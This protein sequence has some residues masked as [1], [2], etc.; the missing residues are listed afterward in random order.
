MASRAESLE[1]AFSPSAP[2]SSRELFLGRFDQLEKTCEAITQRG[3]H[4]VIYGERGV[5]KTSLANIISTHI[6][7]VFVIK[8]TCHRNDDFKGLWR[9]ALSKVSFDVERQGVGFA[10]RPSVE[11]QQLDMF[12]ADRQDIDALDVQRVFEKVDSHLV[13]LFDEFDS[14]QNAAVRERFADTVKNLSDNATHVTLGFIGIGEDVPQLIGKHP[15]IERCMRQIHMPRMSKAE[16]TQIIDKG[17]SILDLAMDPAVKARIVDFSSGFPHFTH[18][19]GKYAVRECISRGDALVSETHYRRALE[20]AIEDVDQSIRARYQKA[21]I[22]VKQK[23]SRFEGALGACALADQ[24]EYGTF[25]IKDLTD[26]FFRVTGEK[27][28]P[29]ALAYNVQR[30]CEENRG[31]ILTKV[32]RSKNVRYRFSSPLLQVFIKM[33]LD[34]RGSYYQPML[35][36]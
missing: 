21:T 5:G 14:V 19:L 11:S 3:Q 13:F 18:L 25:A 6:T 35:F 4:F 12:I 26:P 17:L 10:A 28:K 16:L 27:T 9:K 22:G 20:H 23:K 15:S 34:Q 30:L 33:K 7:N 24:D 31:G 29:G 1:R 36:K 8:V 2:I 32:G